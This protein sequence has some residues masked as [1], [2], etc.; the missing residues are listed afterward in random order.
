MAA[1]TETK[2][3]STRRGNRDNWRSAKALWAQLLGGA[4]CDTSHTF[5]DEAQGHSRIARNLDADETD[6]H[7]TVPPFP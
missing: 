4:A 3:Q 5:G 6:Y 1:T 7:L 2:K